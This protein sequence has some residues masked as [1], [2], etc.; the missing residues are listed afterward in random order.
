M[1]H[2]PQPRRGPSVCVSVWL[3][4][5]C[6]THRAEHRDWCMRFIEPVDDS[7]K[8]RKRQEIKSAAGAKRVERGKIDPKAKS[9]E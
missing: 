2:G 5:A 8:E 6:M 7:G 3:R 1:K 4:V 9:K